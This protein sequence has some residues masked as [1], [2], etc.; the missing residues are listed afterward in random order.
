MR[1]Y[2]VNEFDILTT[3][4]EST[5]GRYIEENDFHDLERFIY[6]YTATEDVDAYSFL[7]PTARRGLNRTISVK[8]Y[9]GLIQTPSAQFE[10]LPKIDMSDDV[11]TN[12]RIFLTMLRSMKEFNA[13]SFNLADLD[14]S[15][16]SIYEIFIS[17]YLS[18]V[19]ELVKKG[20]RSAYINVEENITAFMGKLLISQ[21][22]SQN[23]T[24]RERFYMSYDVFS[25]DRAENRLIK[26]T[27]IKLNGITRSMKSKQNI[28][29]L[30]NSFENI[31]ESFNYEKDFALI[32]NDRS[33]KAYE[34]ILMWSKIFLLDK[35][36]ST[37][38][39][40]ANS[41]AL[42]FPMEKVFE[43]YVADMIKKQ[44]NDWRVSTQDKGHY[45]FSEIWGEKQKNIFALRPDIVMTKGE[46]RVIMDTKWK[47]LG[48]LLTNYGISQADMY[49]MYAYG[50]KYNT[51]EIYLLYPGSNATD[52]MKDLTFDSL[53]NVK[54][55][56]F[57]ID[58]L[59]INDSIEALKTALV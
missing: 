1:S 54:V 38:K 13:K 41:R 23:L 4:K 39:G 21:Q 43:S 25:T 16:N 55:K 29:L 28:R 57:F 5:Y 7:T 32:I 42:L 27:L 17:M 37:F 3:H 24:H 56:V 44:M 34:L 36:F 14:I 18:E 51:S 20:I 33:M 31:S 50:K 22:L 6:E 45:L 2:Q 58:L 46:R 48:P 26:S 9:V 8:N 52:S 47:R 35:S 15:K 10:I 59:N 19:K 12:K 11:D 40:S 53:D 30:L 49:Q